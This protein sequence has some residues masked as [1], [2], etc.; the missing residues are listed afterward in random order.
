MVATAASSVHIFTGNNISPR[1]DLASRSL[2]IRLNVD[3]PDPENREFQH[4]DPL[5]WTNYH[6]ASILAALY[7]LLLGN[8]ELNR[9]QD[10]DV[11]TRFKTWWRLVGSSVEHAAELCRPDEAISFKELFLGLDAE[12]EESLSLADALEA[13]A[14]QW[15]RTFLPRRIGPS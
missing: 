12:D 6:R 4:P 5:G 14:A 10:S 9:A 8:P 3:R 7:T 15:P 13:M 1:G 11:A 2:H